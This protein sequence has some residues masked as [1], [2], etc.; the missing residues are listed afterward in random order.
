ML[1]IAGCSSH[2]ERGRQA[3]NSG[4]YM[5]SFPEIRQAAKEGKVEAQYA[6][7]YM[8]YYGNG[9][10]ENKRLAKYWISK[11]AKQG[12]KPAQQALSL[13]TNS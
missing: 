6:L 3:F 4:N 1:A 8:Y 9:V 13:I 10:N 7:G 5:K 11:S 2:F 12:Y